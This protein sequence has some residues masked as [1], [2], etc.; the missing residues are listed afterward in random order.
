MVGDG[1]RGECVRCTMCEYVGMRRDP[2]QWSKTIK[3][4]RA[5]DE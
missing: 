2:I 3:Y 5:S 1:E 4:K